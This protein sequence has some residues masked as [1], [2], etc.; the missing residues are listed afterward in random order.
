MGF[1]ASVLDCVNKFREVWV[2]V[3]FEEPSARHP[4]EIV[5]ANC[6]FGGY[7]K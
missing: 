2:W 5:N 6:M 7:I 1:E 4:T 3:I